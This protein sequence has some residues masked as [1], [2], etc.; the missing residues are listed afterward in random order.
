MHAH[1]TAYKGKIVCELLAT[2]SIDGEVTTSLDKPGNFGQIIHDTAKHL[3]VSAEALAL[4]NTM[5]AGHDSLGDVDW[6]VTG[7]DKASFGWIGGPYNILDPKE[8]EPS[9]DYKVL[10]H[11]VI[12]NDVPEGAKSAIDDE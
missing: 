12:P 11:V 10:D 1:I 9:R 7:D 2:K 6:F 4:L 5:R 8:C 3:G